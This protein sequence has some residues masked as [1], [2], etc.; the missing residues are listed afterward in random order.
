MKT[1]KIILL[2]FLI[3]PFSASGQ[4]EG[5]YCYNDDLQIE[6]IT[7]FDSNKF[8]YYYF[9]CYLLE[10]SKGR[11][12]FKDDSLIL[13]LERDS[14]SEMDFEVNTSICN[15]D[16]IGISIKLDDVMVFLSFGNLPTQFIYSDT[17]YKI[18]KSEDSVLLSLSS[19]DFKMIRVF[20]SFKYKL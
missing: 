11:Y 5:E 9:G 14:I 16:S 15:S 17:V 12:T 2:F 19:V 8:E 7:F 13:F 10:N 4:L 3:V 6:C 20:F 18:K 1:I